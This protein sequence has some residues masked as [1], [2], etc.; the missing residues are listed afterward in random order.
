MSRASRTLPPATSLFPAHDYR[1]Q[2][3]TSVSEELR[4]NPRLGEGKTVES[5]I[6]LMGRLTLS[7]PKRMDE[8][9][10]ANQRVSHAA[11]VEFVPERA[12]S[13]SV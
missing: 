13:W 10:P 2:T 12:L 7:Y 1:G 5:F 9:V 3:Q 4:F 8:A 6:E 11:G